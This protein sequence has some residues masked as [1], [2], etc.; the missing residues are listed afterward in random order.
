MQI[1]RI[2]RHYHG[3]MST[4]FVKAHIFTLGACV[5]KKKKSIGARLT[6]PSMQ[7]FYISFPFLALVF[8]FSYLPLHGW[9]YALFDYRIGLKL[10]DTPFVG[11]KYFT[12]LFTNP[13]LLQNLGRVMRN[14]LAISF[15]DLARSPLPVIMAILFHEIK[16]T[17]YKKVLQTFTT[18]PNFI[19]WVIIY[20][21]AFAMFS[22]D[23]GFINHLL[24]KAGFINQ[25]IRFM[26]VSGPGVWFTMTGYS[27]WKG[28]GWG[29]II[30]MA[31]I[32]SISPELYEAAK[33]DGA[34]RFQLAIYITVPGVMPTYFVLLLLSIA[35]LINNGMEQYYVF[36]NP[37]NKMY[38]E[39]LD[40]Y[41]YNLGMVSNNIS[42]ATAIGIMKTFISTILLFTG[43]YL[44]KLVRG[45]TMI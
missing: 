35:S 13:F 14:T 21:L 20:A 26:G 34:N 36:Q 37:M 30:Y 19:S 38:I 45:Q 27:I 5:M 11:L 3:G 41:V 43:N 8:V 7:L 44:S 1:R 40:L 4:S 29:T 24:V 31:A 32:S 17:K 10:A 2:R 39:V 33:V 15:L 6:S 28:L 42:S 22:V 16:F 18:L 9:A 25:G 23:D 12:Q